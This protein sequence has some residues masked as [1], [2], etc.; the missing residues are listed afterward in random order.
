MAGRS[1]GLDD[2]RGRDMITGRSRTSTLKNIRVPTQ[3]LM[4]VLARA[5]ALI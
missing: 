3:S 5:W 4:L 2:S 1:I